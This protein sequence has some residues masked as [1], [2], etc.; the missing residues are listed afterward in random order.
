M[1]RKASF[2]S[3]VLV[4]A[5]LLL[6]S[7]SFGRQAAPATFTKAEW[8]WV[9]GSNTDNQGGV[10]G[11]KGVTAPTNMPGSRQQAVSWTD[12][13]GVFWVFGG[14]GEDEFASDGALNDL[15]K[16]DGTNWTWMGG[17]N[18]VNNWGVYGTRG[19]ANP[20]NWPGGRAQAVSWQDAQGNIWLFG[21]NGQG[22]EPYRGYLNDLWKW[23]GTNWTWMA[24]TGTIEQQGMYATKGTPS[25]L[26]SPGSRYGSSGWIDA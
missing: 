17:S 16:F 7:E 4:A 6:P 19:I 25:P 11:T 23:D 10:Y 8:T 24:G 5:G 13:H 18:N 1:G 2:F 12:S 3:Y 20:N 14:F 9:S 26:N 15:W 22:Q 21:G